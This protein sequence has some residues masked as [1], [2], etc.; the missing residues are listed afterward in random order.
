M[1]GPIQNLQRQSPNMAYG[2]GPRPVL[3]FEEGNLK[4]VHVKFKRSNPTVS[5]DPTLSMAFWQMES[6]LMWHFIVLRGPNENADAGDS[7]SP[8]S[9]GFSLLASQLLYRR[10]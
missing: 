4:L 8:G 2:F 10:E 1:N 7:V 3:S 6:V 5:L 9:K